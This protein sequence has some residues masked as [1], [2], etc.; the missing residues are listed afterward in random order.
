MVNEICG[1]FEGPGENDKEYFIKCGTP[2]FANYIT[3]Q[4]NRTSSVLQINEL[5]YTTEDH[6]LLGN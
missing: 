5:K 1:K 2:L 4:I 6:V 3:V